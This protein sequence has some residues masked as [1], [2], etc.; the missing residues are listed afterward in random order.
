MMARRALRC[1]G[2]FPGMEVGRRA[3]ASAAR[4]PASSKGGNDVRRDGVDAAR[5]VDPGE[6]PAGL[7][8][9]DDRGRLLV[10][11]GEARGHGFAIVV[12]PPREVRTSALVA[13][14]LGAGPVELVVI[15]GAAVGAGESADDALDQR[16]L[17]DLDGD[18]LVERQPAFGQHA[19][20][21]VGLRHR[22]REAVED[23][24]AGAVR[25]LDPLG[26]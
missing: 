20:Q 22:A 2:L 11:G 21:R 12:R 15:A 1:V 9:G 7:V 5:A 3:L 26:D 8:V 6:A 10:V 19:V 16:L 13:N 25:L 4:R 24:T 18:H 14:A 23:E 17:I